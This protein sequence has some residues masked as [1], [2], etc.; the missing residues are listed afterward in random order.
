MFIRCYLRYQVGFGLHACVKEIVLEVCN[1]CSLL[2]QLHIQ[3]HSQTRGFGRAR[4]DQEITLTFLFL[5]VPFLPSGIILVL[6]SRRV[7]DLIRIL[8]LVLHHDPQV[9]T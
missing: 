7:K 6:C 8:P 5:A 3:Q 2:R 4:M 9:I 1:T